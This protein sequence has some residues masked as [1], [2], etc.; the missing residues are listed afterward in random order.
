MHAVPGKSDVQVATVMEQINALK[1]QRAKALEKSV[2]DREI[3]V[4][5]SQTIGQV[6]NINVY[7]RNLDQQKGKTVEDHEKYEAESDKATEYKAAIKLLAENERNS[8]FRDKRLE[9][10]NKLTQQQ[11]HTRSKIRIR[12]PDQYIL[13][14]TFGALE[15]IEA[16]Y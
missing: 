7:F 6:S 10:L 12:F 14:G 4:F 13:E 5:N 2:S 15:K 9:E 3:R 11:V 1:K 8:K 16:V